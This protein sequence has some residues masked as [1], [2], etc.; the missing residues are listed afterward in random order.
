MAVR[1][2]RSTKRSMAVAS[3]PATASSRCSKA[4]A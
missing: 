4:T 2:M 3:L 1:L